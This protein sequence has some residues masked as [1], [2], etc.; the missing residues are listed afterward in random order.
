MRKLFTPSAPPIAARLQALAE[1]SGEGIATQ[2]AIAP[3]LPS[4]ENFP[5]LLREATSRVCIDDYFNGDGSGGKRTE[6][7]GLASLYRGAWTGGMVS[8]GCPSESCR[9]YTRRLSGGG[10]VPKSARF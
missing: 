1:L 2:A 8:S 3:L 5:R 9:A 7:L 10:V 4:S 6:R